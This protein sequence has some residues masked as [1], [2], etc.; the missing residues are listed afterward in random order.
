MELGLTD[1]TGHIMWNMEGPKKLSVK[2]LTT[3]FTVTSLQKASKHF[4]QEFPDLFKPELG[5]LKDFELE[6]KFK[7]KARPIF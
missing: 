6:V 4:C 3:E 7:P 5:C 1:I 2:Q